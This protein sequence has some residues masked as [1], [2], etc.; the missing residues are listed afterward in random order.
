VPEQWGAMLVNLQESVGFTL[1][2]KLGAE[3]EPK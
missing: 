2:L 1:E 3:A